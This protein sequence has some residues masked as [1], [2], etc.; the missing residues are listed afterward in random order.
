MASS[1]VTATSSTSQPN[2]LARILAVSASRRRVDVDAGHAQREQ[3]H[4]HLGRLEAHAGR[5]GLQGDVLLDLDDLLV[6]RHLLRGDGRRGASHLRRAA[7]ATS[8]TGPAGATHGTARHLPA[9]THVA[10]GGRRGVGRGARV[11]LDATRNGRA[12]RAGR[13][14][15][16]RHPRATG[17]GFDAGSRSVGG[18][19]GA[20]LR[21]GIARR[22]RGR[23]GC[24]SGGRSGDGLGRLLGRRHFARGYGGGSGGGNRGGTSRRRGGGE[25]RRSH[26]VIGRALGRG[27]SRAG[28]RRGGGRVRGH[29]GLSGCSC[30]T[31][32]ALPGSGRC[33][34]T[35]TT[36]AERGVAEGAVALRDAPRMRGR[37]RGDRLVRERLGDRRR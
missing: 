21:T 36:P 26:H 31:R 5:Q 6:G 17:P 23:S 29:G 20:R 14:D 19:R 37:G 30:R 35:A 18:T 32:R 28:S 10:A 11:V 2:S 4:Q 3:L 7:R 25:G 33:G 12:R 13:G 1:S 9:R 34:A 8:H 22:S 27:R 24:C 15:R 16:H